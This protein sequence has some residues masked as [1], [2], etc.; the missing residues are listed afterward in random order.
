[1]E[2]IEG[3][4]Q[5]ISRPRSS[6][7]GGGFDHQGFLKSRELARNNLVKKLLNTEREYLTKLRNVIQRVSISLRDKEILSP[8]DVNTMFHSTEVIY[9][10]NENFYSRLEGRVTNWHPLQQIGDV[11]LN[12]AP[13]L[14]SYTDY[15]K[16]YYNAMQ[17]LNE[18]SCNTR[19]VEFMKDVEDLAPSGAPPINLNEFLIEPIRRMRQYELLLKEIY[20]NTDPSHPDFG[21]LT[22]AIQKIN[23]VS[24]FMDEK[25]EEAE[26]AREIARVQKKLVGSHESLIAP[27]RRFMR[28]GVLTELSKK[29]PKERL[30]ILF[31]DI[32]I[33]AKLR[34]GKSTMKWEI[35]KKLDLFGGTMEED[36]P[37][38]SLE[39]TKCKFGF[40]LKC[41]NSSI[42]FG[43]ETQTARGGWISAISRQIKKLDE[44]NRFFKEQARLV[45]QQRAKRAGALLAQQYATLRLLS[46]RKT[47]SNSVGSGG[48]GVSNSFDPAKTVFRMTEKELQTLSDEAQSKLT[49]Q[50]EEPEEESIP[51]LP[52][53]PIPEKNKIKD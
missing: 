30:V 9:A 32:I 49:E 28:E 42:A 15:V 53:Q 39:N 43:C 18:V 22:S 7:L 6:S 34:G 31:S 5:L 12:M 10:I 40:T 3:G 38:F 47:R 1:M 37:L 48:A 24:L 33:T 17:K 8:L 4:D 52:S 44:Q 26:S 41:K 19:F 2:T 29:K 16:T 11:F 46:N 25:Q 35:V 21:N 27:S 13:F 20:K 45:A 23:A 36:T 14:K 51:K 50:S